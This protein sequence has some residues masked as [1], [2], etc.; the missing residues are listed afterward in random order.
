LSHSDHP[1][2]PHK[3]DYYHLKTSSPPRD[4]CMKI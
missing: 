1:H 3:K 4:Q 2:N